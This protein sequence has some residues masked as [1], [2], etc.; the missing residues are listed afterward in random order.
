MQMGLII[1]EMA[2]SSNEQWPQV[3][4]HPHMIHVTYFSKQR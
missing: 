4:V 3:G 2:P 1:K